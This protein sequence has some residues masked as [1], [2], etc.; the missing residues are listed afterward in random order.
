[1]WEAVVHTDIAKGFVD[2]VAELVEDAFCGGCEG[3]KGFVDDA[4]FGVV[5]VAL[6]VLESK[7]GLV[8]EGWLTTGESPN[9]LYDIT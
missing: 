5:A 3:S 8:E 2:E 9:G 1:L 6:E 4:G 7:K